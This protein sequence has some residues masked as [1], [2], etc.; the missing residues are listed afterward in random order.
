MAVFSDEPVDVLLHLLPAPCFNM[1]IDGVV[2]HIELASDI[3]L[4]ERLVRIVEHLCV[5]PSSCV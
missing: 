1:A 2:A 5:S 4:V 3:P